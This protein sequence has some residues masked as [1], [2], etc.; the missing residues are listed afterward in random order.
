MTK[1]LNIFLIL[2]SVSLASLIFAAP[3]YFCVIENDTISVNNE[4]ALE[5]MIDNYIVSLG[6][7][8]Y[9]YIEIILDTYN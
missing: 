4:K 9:P 2:F 6:D 1:R 3:E 7:Q 5:S 8:G